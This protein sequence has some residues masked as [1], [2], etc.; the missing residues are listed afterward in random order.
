MSNQKPKLWAAAVVF[1]SFGFFPNPASAATAPNFGLQVPTPQ[2]AVPQAPISDSRPLSYHQVI[3]ERG[4]TDSWQRWWALNRE[5]YLQIQNAARRPASKT[6]GNELLPGM[7]RAAAEDV[8]APTRAQIE[9]LIRPGLQ[10][11]S[12]TSTNRD[13]HAEVMTAL[14]RVGLFPRETGNYLR[15]Y[16]ASPSLDLAQTA[17]LGLGVLEDG[18]A[19][20]ELQALVADDSH[21][22]WMS[23]RPSGV[24]EQVRI[25][26][27]YGIGLAAPGFSVEQ[28]K[29]AG[30]LLLK[31]LHNDAELQDLQAAAV[32]ALGML[33]VG[34]PAELVQELLKVLHDSDL[35]VEIRA[36]CPTSIA[37][38]L[39]ALP[40]TDA[41][42]VEMRSNLAH[43]LNSRVEAVV[44]QSCLQALGVL[45][46]GK[47]E[48]AQNDA[49][50]LAGFAESG[51]T[52]MERNFACV[53]LAYLGAN[54][55]FNTTVRDQ[56]VQALLGQ[57]KD[58]SPSHRSWAALSLGL[59]AARS[60]DWSGSSRV[61]MDEAL[62]SQFS[63]T[64][65]PEEQAACAIA[66]GLSGQMQAKGLLKKACQTS[67]HPMLRGHLAVAL[68]LLQDSSAEELLLKQLVDSKHLPSLLERTAIGLAL[69][70]SEKSVPA[71]LA[72]IDPG[73]RYTPTLGSLSA[74]ARGLGLVGNARTTPHLISAMDNRKL[75]PSARAYAAQALG[76]I[77]DKDALP[78]QYRIS[79][80]INYLAGNP[81]L[82]DWTDGNGVLDRR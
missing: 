44:R 74:A 37:H 12:T 3:W 64:G 17:A 56:A 70:G 46:D 62:L 57:M 28:K 39:A 4:A 33:E 15:Q 7:W 54:T 2:R 27:C 29:E 25:Y 35:A 41:L 22:R 81:G 75:T 42:R 26:A 18:S 38:L 1:C 73:N 65:N 59:L 34:Q 8:E 11:L 24:P 21:G 79:R 77:A 49:E 19:W 30:L 69:M 36:H 67:K 71:L 47:S 53:A 68:G 60:Q 43:L 32:I 50:L 6:P 66:L 80:D 52:P 76:L 72:E 58:A 31:I 10:R 14:A 23:N 20:E 51:R 45:A 13:V 78:W 16:L 5:P 48:L 61:Q 40:R 63:N 82:I 9:Y 55:G